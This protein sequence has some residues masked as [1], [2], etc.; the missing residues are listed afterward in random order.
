MRSF[1]LFEHRRLPQ[2]ALAAFEVALPYLVYTSASVLG[3]VDNGVYGRCDSTAELGYT[4]TYYDNQT[5][6]GSTAAA[7][8]SSTV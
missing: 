4:K 6:G 3:T 2:V 5:I 8:V 1:D 7:F